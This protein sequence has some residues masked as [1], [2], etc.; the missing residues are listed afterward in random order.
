MS[1]IEN[2]TSSP[3]GAPANGNSST[4]VFSPDGTKI[5]FV[6]LAENLVPDDVNASADV[7][8]KDLNTGVITRISNG[9]VNI[10][11]G[12]A[13]DFLIHLSFSPDSNQLIFNDSNGSIWIA[14]DLSTS[15]GSLAIM[16]PLIGYDSQFSADGHAIFFDHAGSIYVFDTVNATTTTLVT[17]AATFMPS[18]QAAV[19]QNGQFMAYVNNTGGI[20]ILNLMNGNNSQIIP[21]GSHPSFV[22]NGMKIVFE[23]L[24]SLVP[25]DANNVRDVYMLDGS[26][27]Q[28]TRISIS[29][30]NQD[31]NGVNGSAIASFSAD[32]SK[33]IFYSDASNLVAGD[34]NAIPDIFMRDLITGTVTRINLAPNGDQAWGGSYASVVSQV[35]V[36]NNGELLAFSSGASNLSANDINGLD[37]IFVVSLN[38]APGGITV[39]STSFSYTLVEP[40]Q[41]LVLIG[42]DAHY[43]Y[44]NALDNTL[45]GNANDNQLDGGD[46]NDTLVGGAGNDFLIAGY[47]PGNDTF[48]FSQGDGNDL[49]YTYDG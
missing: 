11:Y 31:A 7:F 35:A 21:Q 20:S 16:T 28:I 15:L 19:S 17:D 44:G 40:E 23:S 32:G 9:L 4:P 43:G 39:Y 14:P 37:D 27:G 34:T 25:G 26:N 12:G 46:G 47:V 38:G 22:A 1:S 8:I 42:P 13:I 49:L 29:E 36:S 6:S 45:T 5:A 24:L 10:P 48:I 30:D 3:F 2:I 41:N 18:A 33:V